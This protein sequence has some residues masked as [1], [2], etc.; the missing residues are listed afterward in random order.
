MER[1]RDLIYSPKLS[2]KIPTG[3]FGD[4]ENI[5]KAVKFIFESDYLNGT[6]VDINGALF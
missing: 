4:P 5:F 6:S 3:K 2:K 1:K